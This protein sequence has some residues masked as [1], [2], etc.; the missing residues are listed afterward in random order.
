MLTLSA[1]KI[2]TADTCKRM[3]YYRYILEIKNQVKSSNLAFG[4][5]IDTA[6]M[7]YL[8]AITMGHQV[9][10]LEAVFLEKWEE[11]TDCEVEYTVTKTPKKL[12]EMG[13]KMVSLFPEAWE[14]SGLMILVMPDG[15]P[16][17]Q[18]QLS[19][20]LKDKL[21]L[22]GYLD[23]IAM[24]DDGEIIVIDLKTAAAKYGEVFAWQ[25][26]QLTAYNILVE[27][28]REALGIDTVDQLGFMCMLKKTNPEIEQPHLIPAR[29]SQEIAEFRQKCFDIETT[30]NQRR[31]YK[32][33]RH[34]F[35]NPCE[36]C[37]FKQLCTFGDTDGLII[38]DKSKPLLQAA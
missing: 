18:V 8:L 28:N 30:F 1:N 9:H 33:S 6:L 36:L 16:A 15:S 35:N 32:A 27:A 25:S 2:I 31:F 21:N 38:P 13:K 11:E 14:K 12:V 3:L 34:A 26:D 37:D 10:D 19:C 29:S 7:T 17:L 24:N 4:S 23:L 20:S 22:R 5:A